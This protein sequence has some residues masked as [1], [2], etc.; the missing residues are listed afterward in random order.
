MIRLKKVGILFICLGLVVAIVYA[1][2]EDGLV[3]SKLERSLMSF[4]GVFTLNDNFDAFGTGII[5]GETHVFLKGTDTNGLYL[6]LFITGP[7]RITHP[8]GVE[9][10]DSKVLG[11]GYR[12]ET[13]IKNLGFEANLALTVGSRRIENTVYGDAYCGIAPEIGLYFPH[14]FF[15]DFGIYINPVFNMFN[16]SGEDVQNKTYY[17]IA[18]KVTWKQFSRIYDLPWSE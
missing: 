1:Q 2:E 15:I 3:T 13:F 8:N 14:H 10:D 6:I 11:I 7:I 12:G 16:F 18:L 5:L 17:D 9:I 4:G